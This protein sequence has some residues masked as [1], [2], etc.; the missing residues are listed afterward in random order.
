MEPKRK[1]DKTDEYYSY[2]YTLSAVL[3]LLWHAVHISIVTS[4]CGYNFSANS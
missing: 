1:N 2:M 4:W 3:Q